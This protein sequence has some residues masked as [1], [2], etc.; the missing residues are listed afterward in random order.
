M[1]GGIQLKRF[2]WLRNQS[3]WEQNQAWREKRRAMMDDFRAI[4]TIAVN[5]FATANINLTDGLAQLAGEA[6][7]TRVQRAIGAKLDTFA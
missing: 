1:A 5:T 6:A 3:V 4:N 2:N 7:A